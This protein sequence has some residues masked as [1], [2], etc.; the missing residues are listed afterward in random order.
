MSL[1][2]SGTMP[3]SHIR[4]KNVSTRY[5]QR[6]V[7]TSLARAQDA[8]MLNLRRIREQRGL[9]QTQLAEAAGCSQPTIS[10]LEKGEKN[11]T[12]DMLESIARALR[13]EPWEL[14]GID[15]FRQRFLDALS[16][17]PESK[18][19]AVLLLLEES[20]APGRVKA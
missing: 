7:Q 8:D 14:F 10:K 15:D 2:M 20:A 13:V 6:A 17:A 9:S 19:Q 1:S 11:V 16:R 5:S 4:V 12:L 18:R 3:H